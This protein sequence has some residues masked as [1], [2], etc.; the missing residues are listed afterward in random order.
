MSL[1][2][3]LADKLKRPISDHFLQQLNDLGPMLIVV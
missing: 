2:I 1:F 3:G